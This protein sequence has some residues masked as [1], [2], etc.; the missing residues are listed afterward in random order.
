MAGIS[1]V[2]IKR[3]NGKVDIKYRI[4]YRDIYGVQHTSPY[5]DTKA[6]AKQDLNKYEKVNPKSKNI[7][8]GQMFAI[9]MEHAE[10][11]CSFTTISD[12]ESYIKNHF[13]KLF[14]V[15]YE[16]ISSID[17]ERF[18][19]NIAIE[20]S[21]H[22]ANQALKKGK[23]VFNYCL[24][25][26]L[27][28]Q[29]KFKPISKKEV[30]TSN[31]H[32]HLEIHELLNVLND[33]LCLYPKYFAMIYT[34]VGSG[35][36][37]GEVIALNKEDVHFETDEPYIHVCKQFTKRKFLPY[38]KKKHIRDVVI[39]DDLV[40]VLKTHIE[41]LPKDCDLLFP[42]QVGRYYN[43]SNLRNR[44]WKPL[45]AYSGITKRVRIHDI[46]GSYIDTSLSNGL[47]V[48]FAQGQA[49]HKQSKTTLDEYA[50]NND[51]MKKKAME[52]LNEIFSQRKHM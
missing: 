31:T 20:H 14:D 34:L 19:D 35:M 42:N 18:I 39:F 21:P 6:L 24:K 8:I 40:E 46:R 7:T 4:T 5:Y 50:R 43:D 1:R 13:N 22:V 45:L 15:K 11:N 2:K 23:A 37:I 25:H 27:I 44:I 30:D 16:K 38:T 52:V 17:L 28:E 32:F 41:K 10:K 33:C 12:T 48:K 51:A 49:G 36:R 47:S 26:G 3:A 9:Y 29:N